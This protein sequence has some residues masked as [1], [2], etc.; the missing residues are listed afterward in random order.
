MRSPM[1]CALVVVAGLSA[2]GCGKSD[3][4][5]VEDTM[6]RY[7]EAYL[8]ADGRRACEL[9]TESLRRRYQSVP[10]AKQYTCESGFAEVAA[11]NQRN[12][13]FNRALLERA[14]YRVA[15]SDDRATA[16]A[17][18]VGEYELE[19]VDG[20]WRVSEDLSPSVR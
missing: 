5:R 16:A 11:Y 12:A 19:R 10:I 7:H 18:N 15:V 8:A 3:A 9:M 14:R 17:D 20:D 1:A 4:E 13:P 2:F 6:R